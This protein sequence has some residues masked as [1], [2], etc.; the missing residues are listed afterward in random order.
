GRGL[1]AGP[2]GV[3]PSPAALGA[4]AGDA[5][6]VVVGLPERWRREGLGGARTALATTPGLTTLLVRRGLPPGGLAPQ[7]SE[8][9]FTW[10][11]GPS[12]Q[13]AHGGGAG[14]R[15][16]W[17]PG[18]GGGGSERSPPKVCCTSRPAPASR[19]RLCRPL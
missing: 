13:R 7:T 17:L 16:G 3:E 5:G 12:R 6:L 1:G 14:F 2:L 15:H 18:T 10:T 9:R 11:V 19:N 4:A 8:T